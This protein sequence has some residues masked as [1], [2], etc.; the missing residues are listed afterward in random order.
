MAATEAKTESKEAPK[1]VG[2]ENSEPLKYK[3]KLG[4]SGHALRLIPK[5]STLKHVSYPFFFL[6]HGPS[7]S[8]FT[9]K[10]A[11]EK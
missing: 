3:V 7:R 9:A 11:K 5:F 8:L 2:E 6:R 4:S 10:A 1:E